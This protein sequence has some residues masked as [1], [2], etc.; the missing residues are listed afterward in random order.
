MEIFLDSVDSGEPFS[1]AVADFKHSRTIPLVCFVADKKSI[2]HIALGKRGYR[3]AT[4]LRRLNL[5]KIERLS[6]SISFQQI[7]KLLSNRYKNF[8]KTRFKAGG[9]LT[10]KGFNEL[11]KAIRAALLLIC[12]FVIP[13]VNPC[14]G[15]RTPR[16]VLRVVGLR[17]S[18]SLL[19]RAISTCPVA[20]AFSKC[21][22]VTD[23]VV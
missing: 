13:F 22:S 9:L 7:Q 16:P 18:H 4:A 21:K 23:A 6:K 8:I 2:T 15:A 5:Q 11:V 1:E 10:N 14:S 3:S 20:L 17:E 12:V 19:L